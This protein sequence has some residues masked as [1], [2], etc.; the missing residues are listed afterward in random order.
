MNLGN[1]QRVHSRY[2]IYISGEGAVAFLAFLD[3]PLDRGEN[4]SIMLNKSKNLKS[5][6]NS[7]FDIV[8]EEEDRREK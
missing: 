7:N 1:R 4:G 2:I 8:P 5:M 6:S 3:T